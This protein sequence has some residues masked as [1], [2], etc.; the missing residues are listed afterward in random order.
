MSNYGKELILD[1]HECDT[2]QF[3]RPVIQL[4]F[5]D[6]CK[7][8]DMVQRDVHWW[9]EGEP[10]EPHLVGISAVQFIQTSNIVIHTLPAMERVYLNI[11]SCK[12]FRKDV[13]LS[14]CLEYFGGYP[15]S[16]HLIDR[17]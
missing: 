13:A 4:F 1:L 14:C 6:L 17:V 10:N 15:A 11:F 16:S 12:D 7:R 2:S 3:T 9:E 8:I 5:D